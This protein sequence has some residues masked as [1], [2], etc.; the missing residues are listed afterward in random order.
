MLFELT[1]RAWGALVLAWGIGC[2]P[3]GPAL[4]PAGAPQRVDVSPETRSSDRAGTNAAVRAGEP[5]PAAAAAFDCGSSRCRVGGESCCTFGE[6]ATCTPNA[7]PASPPSGQLLEAQIEVCQQLPGQPQ[8]DEIARCRSS[9]HC[10][11]HELCCDEFL[12][13]G[14]SAHLCK[15]S[16]KTRLGCSYGE[17][18]TP[19]LPCR[20]PG[21]VCAKGKCRKNAEVQCGRT[22]CDLTTHTCHVADPRSG[23]LA[24]D[25]DGQI[26]AWR[27]QGR[28]I[29]GITI[30]CTRHADCWA[31]ELCRAAQG[32]TFCQRADDG[33]SAVV[34][35]QPADCPQS[36]CNLAPPGS[37]LVC[38]RNPGAWIGTCDCR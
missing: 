14:S 29:Y 27:A 12:F 31:G 33:M 10:A 23:R 34:C 36:L 28:R 4:A 22:R 5:V 20:S 19:D 3:E 11:A 1:P 17:V 30:A 35:G 6:R 7:P 8:V 32:R 15:A 21:A 25:S 24:C 38:S 2:A 16:D 9:T 37:Q 18:C 26:E 13:S